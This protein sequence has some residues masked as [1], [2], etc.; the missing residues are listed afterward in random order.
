MTS[1]LVIARF[2]H[3]RNRA[4][5]PRN[6][7]EGHTNTK[8]RTTRRQVDLPLFVMVAALVA[9]ATN[10]VLALS[11]DPSP[12]TVAMSLTAAALVTIV[13]G[14]LEISRRKFRAEIAAREQT[15]DA[16]TGLPAGSSLAERVDKAILRANR[17]G[18]L[19][20][21]IGVDLEP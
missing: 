15:Y 12:H 17:D 3:P 16:L 19:V 8:L 10:L 1:H 11:L 5:N 13:V 4:D 2:S 20:T 7:S 14:W 18:G 6:V 9:G 21:V